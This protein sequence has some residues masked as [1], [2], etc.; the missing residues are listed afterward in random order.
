[1][2]VKLYQANCIDI[3]TSMPSGSVDCIITDPPYGNDTDYDGYQ[4]TRENLSALVAA[5][6][7]QALRVANRVVLTPGVRN[8]YLYP[9]YTWILSWVNMAGIGS[10]AWGF[11]C[12]QPII[13]YGKDPYLSD[14]KG[15]RPDTYL[16]KANEVANV[17]H[18]CPKPTNVIKWILTRVSRPG[19]SVCD[20]FMGSGTTGVAC[21]SLGRDF[22][23]IEMSP[24]YYQIAERRIANAQAQPMLWDGGTI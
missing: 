6:M 7:P 21:I 12:W 20:P 4:D 3:L 18:P 13:V 10:S 5:F 19:E 8:I 2:S 11:C 17:N 1:M 24:A 22:I 16:Q 14:G 9:E 23:G 15:R